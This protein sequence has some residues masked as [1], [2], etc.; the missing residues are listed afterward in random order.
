MRRLGLAVLLVL[1]SVRPSRSFETEAQAA[2]L[3][4]PPPIAPSPDE[5]IGTR[6]TD[7]IRREMQAPRK[8]HLKKDQVTSAIAQ[9]AARYLDRPM[10]SERIRTIDGKRYSFCVEPHYH[11]PGSGLTPEGWHKG[12]TVYGFED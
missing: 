11:A 5:M 1:L 3:D 7:P 6:L 4:T 10:M 12:V 8:V 2:T 9:M